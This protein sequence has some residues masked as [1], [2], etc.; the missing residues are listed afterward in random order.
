MHLSV[1]LV[2]SKFTFIHSNAFAGIFKNFVY[3]ITARNTEHIKN[4]RSL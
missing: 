4:I 3:L 1:N 2:Y